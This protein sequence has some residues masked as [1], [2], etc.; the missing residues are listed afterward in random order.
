MNDKYYHNILKMISVI[1]IIIMTYFMIKYASTQSFWEDEL[2]WT[3]GFFD[4]LRITE[5]IHKLLESGYNLPLFYLIM[6][7]IY[8]IAPF[9]EVFLL[10]PSIIFIII[11]II[12]VAKIGKKLGEPFLVCIVILLLC[13]SKTLLI[14]CAW[15]F[16]PYALLFCNSALVLLTFINKIN[17]PTKKN[18]IIYGICSILLLYTHWFGAL[19]LALYGLIDMILFFRKKSKIDWIISYIIAGVAFIPWMYLM[20]KTH[21]NDLTNYWAWVPQLTTPFNSIYY[22]LGESKFLLT[23]FA[24]GCLLIVGSF[25][26]N[27]LKKKSEKKQNIWLLILLSI[28]WVFTIIV[29]YSIYINPNG[30]LYVLRYFI[31]IL[32]HLFLI[33]SYS[34]IKVADIIIDQLKNKKSKIIMNYTLKIISLITVIILGVF[35]Y[36]LSIASAKSVY[37][38]YREA[39]EYLNSDKGIYSNE[40]ILITLSDDA[41]IKYYFI[42]RNYPKPY[43]FAKINNENIF[44]F[45]QDNENT[46]ELIEGLSLLNSYNTIYVL[47][48]RNDFSAEL[49]TFLN[50][51]FKLERDIPDLKMMIYKKTIK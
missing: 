51:N 35:S 50:N 2:K 40:S 31:V 24:I 12:I 5:M 45:Y 30:S 20:F 26:Y 13:T 46:F 43:N 18:I 33:T 3:I 23:V 27:L 36:N 28:I 7:P 14:S 22:L 48:S 41:W 29:I 16:R 44:I 17:E 32:P 38:P 11:G 34:Y 8:Q 1:S 10:I 25:G 49:Y 6:Y 42:K 39:S 37:E 9:G 4:G 47:R 19:L 15:E 21:T